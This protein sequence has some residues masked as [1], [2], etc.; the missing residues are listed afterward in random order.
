MVCMH[1]YASENRERENYVGSENTPYINPGTPD[2]LAQ[3]AVSL[4]H[5]AFIFN[6]PMQCPMNEFARILGE[7]RVI[8][9]YLPA[10]GS[11]GK[12]RVHSWGQ[13]N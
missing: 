11:L 4:P 5:H 10:G 12:E 3:R 7:G 8:K 1:R 6:M 9:L 13:L 2:T